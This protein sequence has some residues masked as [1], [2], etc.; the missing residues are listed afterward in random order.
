MDNLDRKILDL[1]QQDATMPIAELALALGLSNGPCWR[2][3]KKL[4]SEGYIARRV[5][6]LDRTKANVPT[7]VFVTIRTARHTL[8]WLKL[9]R[10]AID[11]IPEIIGAWRLTGQDDYL[12]QIVVPDVTT[13][14]S[15]YKRIITQLEFSDISASISMEEI[16]CTTAVPTNYIK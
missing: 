13:Y 15:V 3:V 7:T 14:D 4:E 9:F 5:A 8:E 1:L 16:K 11:R 10:E 12:L 2:R 6:I